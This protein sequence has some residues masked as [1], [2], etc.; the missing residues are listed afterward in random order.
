MCEEGRRPSSSQGIIFVNKF[1]LITLTSILSFRFDIPQTIMPASVRDLQSAA[2]IPTFFRRDVCTIYICEKL[3]Y[4]KTRDE[5]ERRRTNLMRQSRLQCVLATFPCLPW[6]LS[7]F[8]LFNWIFSLCSLEYNL[9]WNFPKNHTNECCSIRVSTSNDYQRRG[10]R[11]WNIQISPMR[12]RCDD[13][14]MMCDFAKREK[15]VRLWSCVVLRRED[16]ESGN[17]THKS[18]E[19]EWSRWAHTLLALIALR[20]SAAMNNKSCAW[21]SNEAKLLNGMCRWEEE[22]QRGTSA[23]AA[24]QTSS[25]VREKL[26]RFISLFLMWWECEWES[27]ID[28]N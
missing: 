24:C 6:S 18:A 15:I 16:P 12:A 2:P 11:V 4:V 27:R 20:K 28:A 17:S 23:A 3:Y 10:S 21:N 8:K 26:S 14:E 9:K 1:S 13:D 25:F 7:L 19:L 5:C 22:S